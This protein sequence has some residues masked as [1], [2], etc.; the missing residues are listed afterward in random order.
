MKLQIFMIK[1]IP[2]L[3]FNHTCLAVI[4]LDSALK[5]DDIYYLQVFLKDCKYIEKKV[6]RQIHDSLSGFCYSSDESVEEQIRA[7]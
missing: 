5:E 4:S 7:G 3:D 6:V 2:K 1:K